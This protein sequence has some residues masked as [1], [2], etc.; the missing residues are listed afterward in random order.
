MRGTHRSRTEK[1]EYRQVLC[2][3]CFIA[4][5]DILG[6]YTLIIKAVINSITKEKLLYGSPLIKKNRQI[7]VYVA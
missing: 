6:F 4:I 5:Y 7:R 3:P 2:L 1:E